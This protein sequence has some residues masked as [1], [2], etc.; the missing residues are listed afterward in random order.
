MFHDSDAN[1][2]SAQILFD[3]GRWPTILN[4]YRFH[5]THSFGARPSSRQIAVVEAC[6]STRSTRVHRTV[7]ELIHVQTP[8]LSSDRVFAHHQR[9]SGGCRGLSLPS[10]DTP[11]RGRLLR[12]LRGKRPAPQRGAHRR[13]LRHPPVDK[14]KRAIWHAIQFYQQLLDA[15]RL[16]R[17]RCT[18]R[19][20]ELRPG[21]G[22][23]EDQ[24]CC[25]VRGLERDELR[26]WGFR[27]CPTPPRG[28][29]V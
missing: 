18:R 20:P 7:L 25:Y 5:F 3:H 2:I 24:G 8:L 9:S 29:L 21:H 4:C 10:I 13:P 11:V 27:P 12:P 22:A 26:G 15:R 6:P 28:D 17:G 19:R 1:G 14:S 16:N 23:G